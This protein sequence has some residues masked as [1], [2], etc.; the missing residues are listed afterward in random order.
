MQIWLF[1]LD[2]VLIYP[3]GYRAAL[4]ATINHWS[5]AMDL[6]DCAPDDATIEIFE[7][8]GITSEWDSSAICLAIIFGEV[9]RANPALHLPR[10]FSAAIQTARAFP[11]RANWN[12]I[13]STWARRIGKA[14]AHQH[15]PPLAAY[16]L[17]IADARQRSSAER[18][19]EF[20]FIAALLLHHAR[21]FAHSP[22]MRV[23]Q[24]YTL[25]SERFAQHFGLAAEFETTS[26][27]RAFDRATLSMEHHA[28]VIQ[29]AA[30]R[31]ILSVIYTLRPCLPSALAA[32]PEENPPEAEI[33][34]DMIGLSATP[35]IGFGHLAW[36]ARRH[37]RAPELFGKPSPVHALAAIARAL[38]A[39]EKEA[40]SAAYALAQENRLEKIWARADGGKIELTVFEDSAKGIRGVRRAARLLERAEIRAPVRAFGIATSEEKR[41]ALRALNVAVFDDVNDALR[42]AWT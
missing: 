26:F 14:L 16:Q 40:L 39:K 34:L 25:G 18:V 32:R 9:W 22:T 15:Q 17:L 42:A 8:C 1:D 11:I 6:G 38:G 12:A 3:G 30:T 29:L 4:K 23:F 37:P 41:A 13:F 35:L 10:D 20:E 19:A 31:E 33:A 21:D 2:G 27:L 7:A 5:R 36:L 24:H 28:R